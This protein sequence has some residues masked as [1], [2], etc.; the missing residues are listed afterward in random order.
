MY[1]ISQYHRLC[2]ESFQDLLRTL[3]APVRAFEEE[4]D[5]NVATKIY[6]RYKVW[7]GNI[8]AAHQPQKRISLDYRLRD[9][10]FYKDRVAGLLQDLTD[11]NRKGKTTIPNYLHLFLILD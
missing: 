10:S 1:P 5:I 3:A 4:L 11:T 9:A 6:G 2:E 8:G 7:V